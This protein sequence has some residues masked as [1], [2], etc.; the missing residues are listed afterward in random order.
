MAVTTVIPSYPRMK[1]DR[2]GEWGGLS[3]G[4]TGDQDGGPGLSALQHARAR[5]NDA[6]PRSVRARIAGFSVW[7]ATGPKT[8]VIDER[9]QGRPGNAAHPR[10]HGPSRDPGARWGPDLIPLRCSGDGHCASRTRASVD[11]APAPS[12]APGRSRGQKGRA[13]PARVRHRCR[14]FRL[15]GLGSGPQPRRRS[16]AAT[17]ARN[18][19]RWR[20]LKRRNSGCH[21]TPIRKSRSGASTACTMPS[22]S[23]P[24]T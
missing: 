18:R 12:L 7:S 24:L 1:S 16:A 11:A 19:R 9:G 21:W 4:K 2:F 5:L 22:R 15:Q 8:G 20:A 13:S 3:Q 17:R 23:R 14:T 6:L 10:G